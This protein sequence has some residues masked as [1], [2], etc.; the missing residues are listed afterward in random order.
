MA[1]AVLLVSLVVLILLAATTTV[2]AVLAAY[3]PLQPGHI[4]FSAQEL[5]ESTRANLSPTAG[6]RMDYAHNLLDRRSHDLARLVGQP[7]E[8]AALHALDRALNRTALALAALSPQQRLV[9]SKHIYDHTSEIA[10][11]LDRMRQIE[12]DLPHELE[13]LSAKVAA[14]HSLVKNGPPTSDSLMEL[15]RW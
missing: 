10:E 2:M 4:L 3:S 9:N 14:L 6:E 8:T 1:R 15:S 11:I 12:R 5:A 7:A 13:N